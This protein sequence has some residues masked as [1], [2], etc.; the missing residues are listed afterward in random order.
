M[1]V[2]GSNVLELVSA[3]RIMQGTFVLVV[4]LHNLLETGVSKIHQLL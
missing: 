1:H 2:G 3:N 4:N